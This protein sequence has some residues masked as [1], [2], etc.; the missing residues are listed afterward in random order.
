M[1][2]Q[3]GPHIPRASRLLV[4]AWPAL[5]LLVMAALWAAALINSGG[6]AM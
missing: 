6:M 3:P 5:A 4:M 2:K 1:S